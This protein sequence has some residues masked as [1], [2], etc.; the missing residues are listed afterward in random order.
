MKDLKQVVV[1]A[2]TNRPDVLDPALLRPGR[3]DRVIYVPPPDVESREQ[4]LRVHLKDKPL[5]PSLDIADIAQRTEGYSG[6][7]LA[8][9][10][11]EAA[12]DLVRAANEDNAR[13]ETA[14]F[15]KALDRIQPSVRPEILDAYA[16]LRDQFR[17]G[18]PRHAT[19]AA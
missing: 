11:Y 2:A 16:R 8:S 18:G 19:R 17:R 9:L 4:I 14:N 6:A 5:A 3:F 10:C 12:M 15:L 1:V 13:I 7:D